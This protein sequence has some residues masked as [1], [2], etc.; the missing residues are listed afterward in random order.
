MCQVQHCL[1]LLVAITEAWENVG[2]PFPANC[3]GFTNGHDYTR[4]RKGWRLARLELHNLV[5]KLEQEA[6]FESHM[7]AFNPCAS[8][9]DVGTTPLIPDAKEALKYYHKNYK[10][11]LTDPSTAIPDPKWK[12]EPSDPD[13]RKNV[14]FPRQLRDGSTRNNATFERKNAEYRAGR[15]SASTIAGF[16]N[17]AFAADTRFLLQQLKVCFTTDLGF[18]RLA[19]KPHRWPAFEGIAGE[20][21]RWEE[22]SE[23]LSV[24]MQWRSRRKCAKW[25]QELESGGTDG[26]AVI[27]DGNKIVDLIL[28]SMPKGEERAMMGGLEQKASWVSLAEGMEE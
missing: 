16:E 26:V 3:Q 13:S 5:D 1:D 9:E 4:L 18:K 8:T 19:N 28:L 24:L 12:I 25:V 27:V 2:G 21:P 10:Y 20:H 23:G 15:H 17:T 7:D 11:P 6:V 14:H 22:I